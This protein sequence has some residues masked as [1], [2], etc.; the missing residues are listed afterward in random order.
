MESNKSINTE[1]GVIAYISFPSQDK[2]VLVF[3]G[4]PCKS[5]MIAAAQ[6]KEDLIDSMGESFGDTIDAIEEL[7]DGAEESTPLFD[8]LK[9]GALELAIKCGDVKAGSE[10]AEKFDLDV[11]THEDTDSGFSFEFER[12]VIYKA[13][14][15]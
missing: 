1:S 15:A 12:T 6:H 2:L 13:G 9:P 3:D 8:H 14:Q 5:A 4:I 7:F 11:Y 10:E